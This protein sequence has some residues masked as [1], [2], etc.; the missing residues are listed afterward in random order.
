MATH[1][2]IIC[3]LDKDEIRESYFKGTLSFVFEKILSS[4]LLARKK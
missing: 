4:N 2:K 1:A 3:C